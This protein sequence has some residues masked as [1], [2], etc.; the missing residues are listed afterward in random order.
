[1]PKTL[2]ARLRQQPSS[3][4]GESPGFP[5][6]D[7]PHLRIYSARGGA[8]SLMRHRHVAQRITVSAS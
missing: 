5:S 7:A 8:A 4:I 6:E 1:M 3:R 2:R